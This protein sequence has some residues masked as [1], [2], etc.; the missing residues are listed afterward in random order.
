MKATELFRQRI[1]YAEDKFAELVLWRLPQPLLG[2]GHLYKCRLAYV[3]GEI[4][5]LRYDNEEGKGDHRHWGEVESE[6]TFSDVKK[7]LADF[8]GD[9]ERWNNENSD[10]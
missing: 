8:Q 5:V 6:Y 1:V 7:L 4:C 3:V 10:S 9:I 2:S